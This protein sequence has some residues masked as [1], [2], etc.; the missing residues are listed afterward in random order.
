MVNHRLLVVV[1]MGKSCSFLFLNVKQFVSKTFLLFFQGIIVS[2]YLFF[3]V[4]S[5]FYSLAEDNYTMSEFG[6]VLFKD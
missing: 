1:Y 5:V 6:K 2:S 3:F 4:V